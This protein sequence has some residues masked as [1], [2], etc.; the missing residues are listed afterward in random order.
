MCFRL[1]KPFKRLSALRNLFRLLFLLPTHPILRK[2]H[3]KAV[4]R[5]SL[6]CINFLTWC[7]FLNWSEPSSKVS[8]QFV[9]SPHQIKLFILFSSPSLFVFLSISRKESLRR[10]RHYLET[11]TFIQS[12]DS[13]SHVSRFSIRVSLQSYSKCSV[14]RWYFWKP[15]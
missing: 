9:H 4:L 7:N 13:L 14:D 3:Q 12:L 11:N 15:P 6:T 5:W 8:N 1:K 10:W 2:H